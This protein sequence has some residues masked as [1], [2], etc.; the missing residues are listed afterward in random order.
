[1]YFAILLLLPRFPTTLCAQNPPPSQFFLI[2]ESEFFLSHVRF[3]FCVLC[4]VPLFP[5]FKNT[6]PLLSLIRSQ[7]KITHGKREEEE[8]GARRAFVSTCLAWPKSNLCVRE[9]CVFCLVVYVQRGRKRINFLCRLTILI[10]H[11]FFVF[12]GRQFSYEAVAM[13]V[14]IQ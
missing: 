4:H 10:S 6:P 8:R 11:K 5:P 1:M 2:R 3:L 13:A 7:V 12:F 14:L 9:N